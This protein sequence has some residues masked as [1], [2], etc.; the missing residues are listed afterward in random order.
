MAS[1]GVEFV[2]KSIKDLGPSD[3]YV[4]ENGFIAHDTWGENYWE[5][6]GTPSGEYVV[7]ELVGGKTVS[8]LY[9]STISGTPILTKAWNMRFGENMTP[10]EKVIVD[11]T[12]QAV[13]TQLGNNSLGQYFKIVDL[14]RCGNNIE[15]PDGILSQTNCETVYVTSAVKAKYPD[16]AKVVVPNN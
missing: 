5:L 8:R 7:P 1:K 15:I 3:N 2:L 6:Y 11:T 12:D 13:I 4:E 16:N 10:H 14:T 9:I